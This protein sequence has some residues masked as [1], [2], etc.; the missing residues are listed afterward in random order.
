MADHFM[1]S[2]SSCVP[3][4]GGSTSPGEDAE[5]CTCQENTANKNGEAETT[6]DCSGKWSSDQMFIPSVVETDCPSNTPLA[7]PLGTCMRRFYFPQ[8]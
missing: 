2:D 5:A 1:M 7:H 3:C 4:P 8:L 6:T